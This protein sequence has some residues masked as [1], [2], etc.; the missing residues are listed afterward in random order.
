MRQLE[1]EAF[2]VWLRNNNLLPPDFDLPEYD[3][4]N[5]K[6]E[7]DKANQDPLKGVADDKNDRTPFEI[8]I[9]NKSNQGLI[10]SAE[11]F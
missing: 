8:C 11:V 6:A 2:S 5:I 10:I 1:P 7:Y 9:C 4:E 3:E